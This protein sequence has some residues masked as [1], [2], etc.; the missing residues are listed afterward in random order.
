MHAAPSSVRAT[1]PT[2]VEHT[3]SR[4]TIPTPTSGY[5]APRVRA[6]V[7]H[8]E[9]AEVHPR[10]RPVHLCK[11]DRG[12]VDSSFRMLGHQQP[13]QINDVHARQYMYVPYA[14]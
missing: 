6:G 11:R 8:D 9:E 3:R 2:S 10:G 12:N 1:R 13:V 5:K 14:N 4:P 7:D